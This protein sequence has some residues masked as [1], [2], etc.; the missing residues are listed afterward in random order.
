M[1][2][3]LAGLFDGEG[4]FSVTWKDKGA[5]VNFSLKMSMSLK[6]GHQ[7]IYELQKEF[8]GSIYTYPDGC[9]R[10]YLGQREQLIKATKSL[11][12]YLIIKK[13]IAIKFLSIL[14]LFPLKKGEYNNDVYNQIMTLGNCLN[15]NTAQ[16]R[17][18]FKLY[19]V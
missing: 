13:E 1:I 8:G 11:L 14:D 12:P 10:W 15:P 16:K 18:I 3:Y 5:Y 6:F 19:E 9:V 17:K 4:S 2:E 7:A